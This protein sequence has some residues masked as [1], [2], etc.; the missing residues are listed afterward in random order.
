MHGNANN[1]QR[2]NYGNIAENAQ[3]ISGAANINYIG[4]KKGRPMNDKN[5]IFDEVTDKIYD[6]EIDYNEYKK[7]R[8][9]LFNIICF[10]NLYFPSFKNLII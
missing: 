7:A 1:K 10:F 2:L 4:N 3:N 8:K 5:V 9:Y 6:P